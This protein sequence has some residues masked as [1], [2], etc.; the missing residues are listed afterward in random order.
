MKILNFNMLIR[1]SIIAGD[2]CTMFGR[3]KKRPEISTPSDFEHRVHTGFDRVQGS[4]VGLP[5]QWSSIVEAVPT[6]RPKPIVD[7]SLITP[8]KVQ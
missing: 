6:Y 2:L 8:V 5:S 3:K 4:F 7:P 1:W